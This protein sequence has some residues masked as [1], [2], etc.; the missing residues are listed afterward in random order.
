MKIETNDKSDKKSASDDILEVA[1]SRF[2]LVSRA[3]T[4][5]RAL[6]LEDLEFIS[7]D[8]WPAEVK[9]SRDQDNRPSLTV[10]RLPQFARQITNDQR[11]NR[12]AIKVNPVDDNADVETAET[13]QGLVRH[14][15]YNSSA[16]AAYDTAFESAVVGG[17]GYFRITTDYASPTSFEQ[18]IY[19]KR[20][21]N[22]FSVYLDPM[23]IEP[24]GSDATYGFIVEDFSK[25]DFKARWPNA[26]ICASAEWQSIGD[27]EAGWF[28]EDFIRVA[29]YYTKEF[30]EVEILLLGDGS[31]IESGEFVEGMQVLDKRTTQIPKVFHR[32]INGNEIL[33]EAEWAGQ[34]IP[35]IPVL[36]DEMYIDG[37]RILSG[38][39]RNAKDPQRMLN[40]WIS[41]ETEAI[42]LAPK[43]PYIMAEGQQEG[44][45]SQWKTANSKNHPYLLYKP[46]TLDNGQQVSPPQRSSFEPAVQAITNAR[47]Q[48][49]E[50]LKAT[51]GIYDAALGARSNENSGIAIQRRNQQAQTANFHF[52][53]N[54]S[55]SLKHAGRIVIDLIP[56]I[57]DTARAVRIIGEDNEQKV[58]KINQT[59]EDG[60]QISFGQG[61][62]DVTISNGPSYQTKRQEALAAMLEFTKAMPNQAML[63]TDLIA[64]NMDWPGAQDFADR[65]KIGLPP[66]VKASIQEKDGGPAPLPPEVQAQMAQMQQQMQAMGQQLEVAHQAISTKQMELESKERIEYAKLEANLRIELAK[67]QSSEATLLLES[68]IAQLDRKQDY[69]NNLSN[70][71]QPDAA[72]AQDAF[73][74][75]NQFPTGGPAPGQFEE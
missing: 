25:D 75:P 10:N 40:Y 68:E 16:D 70:Q 44:H 49:S 46:T 43:S 53:D 28:T 26:K 9:K 51:T 54:L 63:V 3:E 65:F 17:R 58:V 37:K 50:D 32:I 13:L 2:D 69:Q 29:D 1:R 5:Q 12:P 33:E 15:E 22:P 71:E 21:V 35:I 59:I 39:V 47:M 8:Q 42:T 7:G 41:A 74:N 48:S 6:S 31:V 27:T 14:I 38:I 4:E 30:R 55:R 67:L 19:I 23:A 61:K 60:K 11:Q 64:K 66:E 52:V 72:G 56:H 20:I 36:G 57:Y 45:E 24:D 34:W 62:Y 18:E 73:A